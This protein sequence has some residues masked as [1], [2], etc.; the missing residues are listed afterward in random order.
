MVNFSFVDPGLLS[1][2]SF[3]THLLAYSSLFSALPKVRFL[4]IATR[5][6]RFEAAQKLFLALINRAPATDPGE[7]ILRYF[8]LRKLWETKQYGKL[9]NDDMEFL[10]RAQKQFNDAPR[11]FGETGSNG[12]RVG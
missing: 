11:T 8:R 1:L 7:E 5:A 10:N 4:Y 12:W 2:D 3:E 6:T 9:S